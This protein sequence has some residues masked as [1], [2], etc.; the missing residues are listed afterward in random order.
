[1]KAI[2]LT[3]TVKE[4]QTICKMVKDPEANK[5][6]P[7][8]FDNPYNVL[9]IDAANFKGNTQSFGVIR[10]NKIFCAFSGKEMKEAEIEENAR[11]STNQFNF[12][13]GF[14]S[15][16]FVAVTNEQ[17]EE[18][19]KIYEESFLNDRKE[20]TQERYFEMLN[21][22][23]PIRFTQCGNS[24]EFFFVSEAL[25]GSLH[26]L[27]VAVK[28]GKEYKYYEATRE[29]DISTKD[30]IAEFSELAKN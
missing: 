18:L 6:L 22:L 8:E 19:T 25:S 15:A 29:I 20:I 2:N 5:N 14:V 17:F 16:N 24:I 4:M 3:E 10:E 28:N 7:K 26:G 23:P 21:V 27:F 13:D 11:I 9:V 30:I 1:M 12:Y